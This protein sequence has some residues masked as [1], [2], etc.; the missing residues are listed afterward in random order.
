VPRDDSTPPASGKAVIIDPSSPLSVAQEFL[1]RTYGDPRRPRLLRH[2]GTFFQWDCSTW[3]ELG[4]ESVRAALYEFLASCFRAG[5]DGLA[6]IKPNI[7]LVSE[8]L[9][10]LKAVALIADDIEPPVWLGG[11]RQPPPGEIIAFKNGLL[12]LP[13]L[14]LIAPTPGFFNL[15]SLD[16]GDPDP[17]RGNA[18]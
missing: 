18:R 8:A 15:N 11:D 13:T 12:H 14:E 7:R 3:S 10:A 5:R 4:E 2:R 9:S 16:I 17:G 6:P 1:A